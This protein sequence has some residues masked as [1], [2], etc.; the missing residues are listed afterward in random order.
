MK[1]K[2]II[3]SATAVIIFGVICAFTAYIAPDSEQ[4]FHTSMW[5]SV[6][7]P[8]LAIILAFLTR[9]VLL[10]LGIAIIVGGLLTKVPQSPL[11]VVAWLEG[12]K[13]VGIY[14]A[15]T[16]TSRANL[17]IL[18]FLPPIFVMIE[19]VIASG[20]FKGIIVWLLKWV[21][22]RKSTQTAT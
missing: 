5:Y 18:A 21:K 11:S 20:G 6:V 1:S 22:G 15:A 10:S 19:I 12:F 16:V 17:Q 4:D 8:I 7:P 13:S 3:K 2:A 14:L 9:H